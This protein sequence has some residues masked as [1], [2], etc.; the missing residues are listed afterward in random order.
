MKKRLVDGVSSI[1]GVSV[2]GLPGYSVS[3]ATDISENMDLKEL[4]EIFGA[5]HVISVSIRDIRAEVMLHALEDKGI[6]VSAGSAC[7][8]HKRTPSATLTAIGLEKSLLESTIR[9]ST[10]IF[11]S[12]EE[13]DETVSVMREIIPGLR[14]YTRR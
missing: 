7:S 2:N 8:T 3:D 13:I 4:S 11:N 5:P 12:E 9:L 6:Y 10:G 1:E 14:K